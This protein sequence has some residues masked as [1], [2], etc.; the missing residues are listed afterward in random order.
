MK[1]ADEARRIM[2][3][4]EKPEV[5]AQVMHLLGPNGVYLLRNFIGF[6]GNI[7][8]EGSEA[9]LSEACFD[10]LVELSSRLKPYVAMNNQYPGLD[11]CFNVI[12]QFE[13]F[14]E[15]DLKG[16]ASQLDELTLREGADDTAWETFLEQHDIDGLLNEDE[17]GNFNLRDLNEVFEVEWESVLGIYGDPEA[18][19]DPELALMA[20]RLGMRIGEVIE[21]AQKLKNLNE[22]WDQFQDSW[23]GPYGDLKGELE[24]LDDQWRQARQDQVMKELAQ[25]LET[26]GIEQLP[27]DRQY[28]QQ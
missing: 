8:N 4:L 10:A 9:V 15:N 1:A 25:V 7:R 16:D 19:N 21:T 20:E 23:E 5:K 12:D 28:A 3:V 22:M 2:E 27:A 13:L 14:V 24:P 26:V 6:D 18:L 17:V 11:N